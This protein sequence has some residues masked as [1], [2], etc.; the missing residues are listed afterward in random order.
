MLKG[1]KCRPHTPK[2]SDPKVAPPPDLA[3]H[4]SPFIYRLSS[5]VFR[6]SSKRIPIRSAICCKVSSCGRRLIVN[7]CTNF[8]RQREIC[9]ERRHARRSRRPRRENVINNHDTPPHRHLL[10]KIRN[11]STRHIHF[12]FILRKFRLRNDERLA[13]KPTAHLTASR[14]CQ[15]S[16]QQF[17]LIVTAFAIPR[18]V[19]RHRHKI[20]RLGK[21][22]KFLP[23]H[24]AFY[25]RRTTHQ[26]RS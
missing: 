14:G 26:V 2:R 25:R 4:L 12:A 24:P 5:I 22:Q 6:L 20:K 9:P 1:T 15:C 10:R 13:F 3:F 17:R 23:H 16:R 11:K 7:Q 8:Q 18:M 19:E 21:H